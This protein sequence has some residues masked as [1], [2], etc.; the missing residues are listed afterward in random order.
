MPSAEVL[1]IFAMPAFVRPSTTLVYAGGHVTAANAKYVL[2]MD[3][4]I[5]RRFLAPKPVRARLG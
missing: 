5:C 1:G 3:P 4:S 2:E